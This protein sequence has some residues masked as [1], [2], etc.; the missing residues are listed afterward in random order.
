M[1]NKKF[2]K[3][4]MIFGAVLL[5]AALSLFLFNKIEEIRAQ[6]N[7]ENVLS[8]LTEAENQNGDGEQQES[9][10]S[11]MTTKEID[12]YDYI[13]YLFIPAENLKLPVMAE[14]DYTRLKISP[15]RF[16]GSVKTDDLII[17]AHNYKKHFGRIYCLSEGDQIIFTDMDGN[18]WTYYVETVEKISPYD[19]DKISSQY[20][21]TLFTCTYAGKSRVVVRCSRG[22]D[23]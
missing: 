15:C 8:L 10:N 14:W 9:P 16:S 2:G 21:L 13:G 5:A 1:R 3:F 18:D 17:C 23:M 12:G 20:A 6:K 22:E 11:E 7:A 4:F 19:I